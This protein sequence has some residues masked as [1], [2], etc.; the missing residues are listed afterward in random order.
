MPSAEQEE[1]AS[2][3]ALTE[4]KENG[5][6]QQFAESHSRIQQHQ[7]VANHQ[8]NLAEQAAGE[9]TRK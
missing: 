1:A 5:Y 3:A 4:H 6:K 7:Q 2:L 8:D 9:V